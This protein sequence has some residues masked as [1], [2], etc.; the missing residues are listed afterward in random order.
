MV[1]GSSEVHTSPGRRWSLSVTKQSIRLDDCRILGDLHPTDRGR[2]GVSGA[3]ER[4]ALA[5]DL[6]PL[7]RTHPSPY[8]GVRAG[9]RPL[10]GAGPPGEAGRTDDR[11]P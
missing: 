3:Q 1:V 10:E 11:D 7:Q 4:V 9:V 6:A 2:A 5:A 8:F